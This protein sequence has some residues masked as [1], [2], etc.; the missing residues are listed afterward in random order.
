MADTTKDDGGQA[1]PV[2]LFPGPMG[3]LH[4]GEPGMTLRDYYAAQA[5]PVVM[6]TM[7]DTGSVK[8]ADP[9]LLAQAIGA[10]VARWSYAIAD[11]M[12]AERSK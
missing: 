12:L 3:D 4:A 6:G 11:A 8:N 2:S 7:P 5:M 1:F 10:T 9:E